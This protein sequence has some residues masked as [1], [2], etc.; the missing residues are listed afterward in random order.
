MSAPIFEFKGYTINNLIYSKSKI[1]GMKF[2]DPDENLEFEAN[3]GF[4]D[5]FS[6]GKL[7]LKVQ[8][9]SKENDSF[10]ILEV[11]GF[12]DI[13][14]GLLKDDEGNERDISDVHHIF[15]VN[16]A[17]ILYP[18]LRSIVSMVTGLDNSNNIILPTIN[19][20]NL[21]MEN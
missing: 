18:Y 8:L 21:S 11:D 3:H 7:G 14:S 4:T 1:E 9:A 10:L 17:A 20:R 5:D 16:A 13:D 6:K 19:L 12:F 15:I 2:T